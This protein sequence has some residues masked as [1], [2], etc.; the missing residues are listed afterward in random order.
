MAERQAED[1]AQLDPNAILIAEYQYIAQSAFQANEDRARVSSYYFV[2]TAAAVAA[3]IGVKIEGVASAG[4]YFGF[5]MVFAVL[6]I[7][8]LLTLLQLARFRSSWTESMRAMDRIKEHYQRHCP[9]M[10]LEQAFAWTKTT[11]PPVS[12]HW[13]VAFLLSLSVML[14]D[15]LAM[16]TAVAYLGLA[17]GASA[18]DSAWLPPAI[19]I[20]LAFAVAQYFLYFHAVRIK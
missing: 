9:D 6:G 20:G 5:F 7:I 11:I 3:I 10:Q 8:G 15:A 2:S 1:R 18:S 16:G 12:K 13:S 19:V 14:V 4:V 17:L